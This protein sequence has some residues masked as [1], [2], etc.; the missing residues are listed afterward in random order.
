M[1]GTTGCVSG[2]PTHPVGGLSEGTTL[3][4]E[5]F[6]HVGHFPPAY[7]FQGREAAEGPLGGRVGRGCGGGVAADEWPQRGSRCRR[8]DVAA[9][10]CRSGIEEFIDHRS[11]IRNSGASGWG[12]STFSLTL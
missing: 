11:V 1:N 4:W 9:G 6:V 10:A 5:L 3:R 7:L 12:M 2:P 8:H